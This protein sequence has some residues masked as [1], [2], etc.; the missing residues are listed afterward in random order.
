MKR[1]ILPILAVLMLVLACGEGKGPEQ[2]VDNF[3]TACKDK[4]K[5]AAL[6]TI[7]SGTEE[8]GVQEYF[9]ELWSDLESDDVAVEGWTE[10]EVVETEEVNEEG[11]DVTEVAW[12][13]TD[14]TVDEGGEE[15]TDTVGFEVVRTEHGWFIFDM[16]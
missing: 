11:V 9:H 3:L 7:Y 15:D 14:V 2:V 4:D 6:V 10:P 1:I 12:V 16:D 13:E 8:T 5:E